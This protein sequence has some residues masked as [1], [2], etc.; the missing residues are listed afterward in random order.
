MAPC[1]YLHKEI[2]E[3][4]LTVDDEC[5]YDAEK[6]FEYLTSSISMRVLF[7][8]ERFDPKQYGDEKIIKESAMSIM[9]FD[10]RI[11]SYTFLSFMMQELE[12]ETDLLQFG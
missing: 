1:N 7:N 11:P 6:Q 5:I 9:Q 2:D 12:D 3:K 8:H 4:G 10:P